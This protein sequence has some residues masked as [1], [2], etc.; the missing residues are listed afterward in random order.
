MVAPGLWRFLIRLNTTA[1]RLFAGCSVT[2]GKTRAALAMTNSSTPKNRGASSCLGTGSYRT[3][4]HKASQEMPAGLRKIE[5]MKRYIALLDGKP[6]AYGVVVPDFPGCYGGG[7]T[8]D[9]AIADATSALSE[10]A[11]DMIADGETIPEPTPVK[12][13][14]A[15]R[16]ASKNASESVPFLIPLLLEKGRLVRANL[17]MDAGTLA[18]IDDEAKRRGVTRS[19]FLASA[20]L[21]KI[22]SQS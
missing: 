13:I 17:S 9:E 2:A 1:A 12:K 10:F 19:A 4:W 7:A 15:G 22:Q 20:A 6:G 8:E 3:A 18:A 16:A 21:E 14:L 11:A 5:A